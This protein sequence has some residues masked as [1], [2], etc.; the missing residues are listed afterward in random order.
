MVKY[1]KQNASYKE[2]SLHL[3][4]PLPDLN[5]IAEI[6]LLEESSESDIHGK[7]LS[8]EGNQVHIW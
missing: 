1:Q 5:G 2:E 3:P 4:L 6:E 8:T 7:Q